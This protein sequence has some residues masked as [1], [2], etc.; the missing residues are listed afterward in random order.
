MYN[1]KVIGT[2]S[3]VMMSGLLHLLDL[4]RCELFLVSVPAVN[5]SSI[6]CQ[7]TNFIVWHRCVRQLNVYLSMSYWQ[8]V[9]KLVVAHCVHPVPLCHHC[10]ITRL[11]LET[12]QYGHSG[13][14]WTDWALTTVH[15]NV[16]GVKL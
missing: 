7:F 6:T 9:G 8:K 12:M 15:Q 14:L 5:N 3:T 10:I 11:V 2:L 4:Y 16:T 13:I 1:S